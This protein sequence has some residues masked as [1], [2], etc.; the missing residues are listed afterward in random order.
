MIS[1]LLKI[2]GIL[3]PL[4]GL[5]ALDHF[6]HRTELPNPALLPVQFP[7]GLLAQLVFRNI[8][9]YTI[10]SSYRVFSRI[11]KTQN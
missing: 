4:I 5:F 6:C 8:A 3:F 2:T 11:E 7:A 1:V 9:G 10:T